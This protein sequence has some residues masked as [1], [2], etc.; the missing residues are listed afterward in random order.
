MSNYTQTTQFGPKD[1]LTTG[2]PNKLIK[3]TEFDVEFAALA[4]AIQTK[5]D[6]SNIASVAQAQAETLNTVL[7][8]PGR[9]GNWSDANAGIVGDLQALTD[10]GADRVLFWDFGAGAAAFLTVSTG[11]TLSGTSLTSDDS[12]IDHDSLSGFV[13]AE[14]VN[15]T[16][17]SIATA[18]D[19]GLTG[20]G[21]I[22]ATRNLS[23]DINGTTAE[24]TVDGDADY[25]LMHDGGS[26]VLRKVLIDYIRQSTV[27]TVAGTTKTIGLADI[28]AYDRYTNAAAITLTVPPNSTTA[29]PIGSEYHFH[30]AG[31]GAITV[32]EG[33]GVTVNPPAEGT[34]VSLGQ[35][36]TLTLKKVAT[37]EWDLIGQTVAA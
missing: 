11:L 27:N 12:T 19:S 22:S 37:N 32:T 28:F 34:L 3:G 4:S 7:M 14:H 2:D 17:V 23:V 25:L 33:S 26:A 9:V 21:D 18:A 13:A 6:S 20:G 10:P 36:A 8:T 5:Y 30:Q 29:F 24:T 16:S 35:H 15:H 1:S 31:A